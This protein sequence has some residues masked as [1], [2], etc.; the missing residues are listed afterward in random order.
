M[1]LSVSPIVQAIAAQAATLDVVLQPGT[2]VTAQVLKLLDADL[3]RIAIANLTLDVATS[4][5]LQAGQTLQL[6]VTQTKDGVSLAPVL[7]QV[8]TS[9]SR[10]DA[11]VLDDT[12]LAPRQTEQGEIR[13]ALSVAESKSVA[14]ATQAAVT[15]QAGLSPLF[16]NLATAVTSGQ[17][18]QPV[19]VAAA[20]LLGLRQPP[21]RVVSGAD[22][23]AALASSGLVFES[24]LATAGSVSATPLPDIKA[25]LTV[26]RQ[27]LATWL[28]SPSADPS[29]SVQPAPTLSARTVATAPSVATS[30][31]SDADPVLVLNIAIHGEAPADLIANPKPA[32]TTHQLL[33]ATQ[34]SPDDTSHISRPLTLPP[35]FRDGLPSAQPVAPPTLAPDAEP[36]AIAQQLVADTD[37]ALA[38]QTLLQIASLP[39]QVA[40]PRSETVQPRWNFE[41]PFVTPQGTAMAQFAISRDDTANATDAATRVWRARFSLNIE[42][43]G[44]VHALISFSGD[45]TSVKMWA[46]RPATAAQLRINATQLSASLDRA[47]LKAGDIVIADGAPARAKAPL[48]GHFLNRA[49]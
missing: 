11:V 16:A 32:V 12:P 6:A 18:P 14:V 26:L 30:A 40:G 43:A 35:P 19:L 2:V 33:L 9:A 22:I 10:A 4:V 46:E 5:P 44:P 28:G 24:S 48:A 13:P 37:G 41:V 7:P 17:L 21:D 42:P 36:A 23:K 39:D 3:V 29:V 45:T 34:V 49:S 25:A 8:T 27:T 15:K 38:R 47:A 31:S 20:Q 1:T